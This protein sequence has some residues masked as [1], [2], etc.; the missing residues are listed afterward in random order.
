MQRARLVDSEITVRYDYK[1]KH[2]G[3]INGWKV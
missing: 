1:S 3:S 2:F